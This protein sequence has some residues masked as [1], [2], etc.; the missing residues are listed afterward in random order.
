[1]YRV[2]F[3]EGQLE[4]NRFERDEEGIKLFDGDEEFVAFVPY[5]NLHAVMD[6]EKTSDSATEP[7]VM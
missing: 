4:C 5:A 3:P 7:S 1:M 2:I 6:E